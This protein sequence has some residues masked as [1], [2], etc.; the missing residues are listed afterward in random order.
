[1]SET[2]MKLE[3]EFENFEDLDKNYLLWYG[4]VKFLNLKVVTQSKIL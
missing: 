3:I 2:K 4:E 1:M